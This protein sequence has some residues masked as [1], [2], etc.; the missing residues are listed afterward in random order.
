M[1]CKQNLSSFN[2]YFEH[3]P[4][5]LFKHEILWRVSMLGFLDHM[6]FTFLKSNLMYSK[7]QIFNYSMFP[8]GMFRK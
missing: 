5:N 4:N 6:S 7:L 2:F 8:I 3:L 1:L